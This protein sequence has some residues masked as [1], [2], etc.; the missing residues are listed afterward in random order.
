MGYLFLEL[1]VVNWKYDVE[2]R[3]V[4]L[5][6]NDTKILSFEINNIWSYN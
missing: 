4:E 1:N 6:N 2:S 3:N 5:L